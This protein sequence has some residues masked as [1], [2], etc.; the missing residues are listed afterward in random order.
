MID[1]KLS[2]VKNSVKSK[3]EEKIKSYELLNKLKDHDENL[4]ALYAKR[5]LKK[6]EIVA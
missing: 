5:G 3:P 1:I 4:K 2:S 6:P